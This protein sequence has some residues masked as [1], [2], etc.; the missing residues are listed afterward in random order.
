MFFN[1][2]LNQKIARLSAQVQQLETENSALQHALESTQA[3]CSAHQS[4]LEQAS[5]DRG[6]H[7]Q[8]FQNMKLFGDSFLEIQKSLATLAGDMKREKAT[9]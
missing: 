2:G 5:V 7:L 8:L 6:L 1:R 9:H 3:D 4:E